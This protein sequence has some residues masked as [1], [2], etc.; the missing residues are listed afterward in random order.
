MAESSRNRNGNKSYNKENRTGSLPE[1]RQN[2]KLPD[3]DTDNEQSM[4][5]EGDT[6]N[7]KYSKTKVRKED[8]E[9]RESGDG[10]RYS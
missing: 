9:K 8:K 5:T 3:L 10:T 6:S 2:H 7:P 1:N 4:S